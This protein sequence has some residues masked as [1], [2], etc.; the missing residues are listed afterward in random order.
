MLRPLWHRHGAQVHPSLPTLPAPSGPVG[1]ARLAGSGL[2][3][4][5]DR[6]ERRAAGIRGSVRLSLHAGLALGCGSAASGEK[7]GSG[8]GQNQR[9]Q[10]GTIAVLGRGFCSRKP[11]V[12]V[13]DEPSVVVDSGDIRSTGTCVI[14]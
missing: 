8:A 6:S 10:Y 5:S 11:G 13:V 12:C 7:E 2:D 1:V 14:G 9:T 4:V 3:G